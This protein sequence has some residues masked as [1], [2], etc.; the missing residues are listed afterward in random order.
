M[1]SEVTRQVGSA[2]EVIVVESVERVVDRSDSELET[3]VAQIR[4]VARTANLEFALRIGAVII[5]HFYDGAIESWR[6]KG[7]KQAS[8]R[9][10]AAHPKLPMSSAALYRC[11]AI[12]ELC[13]RLNAPSRWHHLGA[14]HLRLVLGLGPS[15]QERLLTLA[16]TGQWTVRTLQTH[17]LRERA[18]C[19]LHG[20]RRVQPAIAKSLKALRN[21]IEAHQAVLVDLDEP[22]A[23]DVRLSAALIEETKS[24][25]ERLTSFLS[26]H[27]PSALPRATAGKSGNALYGRR[28]APGDIRGEL[29]MRHSPA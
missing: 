9:R 24:A 16:N 13:E 8:F 26:R 10:L 29:S 27:T 17:A 12:F 14:S 23:E 21:S 2:L 6:K 22:S 19:R 15:V 3:I 1:P 5:H 20:G 28:R 7:P 18:G 4:R 11:V 25:L